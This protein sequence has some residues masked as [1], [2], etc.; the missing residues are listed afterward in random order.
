MT[1]FHQIRKNVEMTMF[2]QS[3]FKITVFHQNE[4]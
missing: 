2:H 4:K 3:L 1:M